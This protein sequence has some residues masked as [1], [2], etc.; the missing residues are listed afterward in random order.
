MHTSSCAF[1]VRGNINIKQ[2]KSH[3]GVLL[4]S[5]QVTVRL[6]VDVTLQF[7]QYQKEATHLKILNHIL[8]VVHVALLPFI[9]PMS[10]QSVYEQ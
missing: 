4:W 7:C 10:A 8:N 5:H 9:H 6:D 3:D 2:G 1:V